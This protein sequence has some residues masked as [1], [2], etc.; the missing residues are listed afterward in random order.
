MALTTQQQTDIAQFLTGNLT[1]NATN[2]VSPWDN[3]DHWV[4]N[5]VLEGQT[6]SSV[7]LDINDGIT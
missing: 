3:S 4:I 6:I 1:L 5:L 2:M 7:T